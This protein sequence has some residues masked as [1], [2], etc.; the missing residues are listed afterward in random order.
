MNIPLRPNAPGGLRFK[1]L[2]PQ[3]TRQLLQVAYARMWRHN[4][5]SRGVNRSAPG[6]PRYRSEVNRRVQL[7]RCRKA[8]ALRNMR[9]LRRRRDDHRARPPS[10]CPGLGCQRSSSTVS[11]EAPRQ[12]GVEGVEGADLREELGRP[13]SWPRPGQLVAPSL[14]L[15]LQRRHMDESQ[16]AL[17]AAKLAN[18]GAGRPP[19]AG[20]AE[21][22]AE[23]GETADSGQRR[24]VRER[25]KR[26]GIRRG[27]PRATAKP[28]GDRATRAAGP[29]TQGDLK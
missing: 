18:L 22:T 4:M 13:G 21:A 14:V 10:G 20:A 12:L 23:A 7:D 9:V 11:A 19:A 3:T 25:G 27:T 28:P 15:G 17:G 24:L 16:R 1:N 2:D 5:V 8:E 29:A 6:G 26:P